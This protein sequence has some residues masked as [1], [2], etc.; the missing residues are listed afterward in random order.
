MAGCAT[1]YRIGV[2]DTL[3]DREDERAWLRPDSPAVAF[4]NPRWSRGSRLGRMRGDHLDARLEPIGSNPGG[5][6]M[7]DFILE[8]RR[9]DS[10]RGIKA[11]QASA[12]PLG[13]GAKK[14]RGCASLSDG[15]PLFKAGNRTRTGDPHLGKVVLYQLSYSRNKKR[16]LGSLPKPTRN[17]SETPSKCALEP[18]KGP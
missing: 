11:L 5:G 1:V 13:Y 4:G 14:K 3:S 12:L 6:N 7:W 16:C 9:P 18:R 2:L 17:V 8:R 15:S 10:N